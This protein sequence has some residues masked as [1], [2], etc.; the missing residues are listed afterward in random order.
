MH[1][2]GELFPFDLGRY[3]IDAGIDLDYLELA[4]TIKMRM[5]CYPNALLA[6]DVPTKKKASICPSQQHCCMTAKALHWFERAS[7]TSSRLG[8]D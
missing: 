5:G 4:E 7:L 6:A 3:T 8:C 2:G 1:A